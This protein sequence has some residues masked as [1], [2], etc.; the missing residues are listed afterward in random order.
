MGIGKLYTFSDEQ[1]VGE[2]NYQ[3]R[4][5][6]ATGWWGEFSLTEYQRINDSGAYIL[7]LEDKRRGSCYL[8]KRVNR[9]VSGVP[10]LYVYYFTGTGPLSEAPG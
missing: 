10:P 3:L 6:S 8:K 5:E 9:A 7:E 2:V 4:D 1:F